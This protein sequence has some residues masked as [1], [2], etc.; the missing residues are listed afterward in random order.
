[1]KQNSNFLFTLLILPMLLAGCSSTAQIDKTIDAFLNGE[2]PST[3]EVGMGLKEALEIGISIGADAL[4]RKDG[5]YLSPYKILLPEEARKV[6]EKLRAVPGFDDLEEDLIEKMNRAA[7]DA[8]KGAKPIFVSA[9]KQMTFQDAWEILLGP[10]DA[11]TA[12]LHST[13]Y[14][15]LYSS[16]QPVIKESMDKVGL[17]DLW[18][19]AINTYN[20]IPFVKKMNPDVDAYVTEKALEGLFSMVEKEEKAIRKE[21]VK[22]TSDLLKKVFAQQD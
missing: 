14:D 8:A 19:S 16:F 11:A 3:E 10:D 13:T 9:I 7:E 18:K 1:M 17:V 4:S 20:S 22:R 6:T 12:Y 21:P 5:Y 15:P 2:K